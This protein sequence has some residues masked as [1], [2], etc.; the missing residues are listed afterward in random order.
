MFQGEI[1]AYPMFLQYSLRNVRNLFLCQDIVCKYWPY[2]Q[3]L[4]SKKEDDGEFQL[5]KTHRP[6]LSVMHAAAHTW[7]CQVQL[8]ISIYL[9]LKV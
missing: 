7:K 6:F 9:I 4:I 1:F 3:D 2:L 5:L 8:K